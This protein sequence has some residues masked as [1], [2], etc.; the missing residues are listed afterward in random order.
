ML[1]SVPKRFEQTSEDGDGDTEDVADG[2][3][4]VTR[5]KVL[6]KRPAHQVSTMCYFCSFVTF[7]L[8][9]ACVYMSSFACH[10]V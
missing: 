2:A 7:T 9:Y 1:F 4:E 6:A 5:K 3:V 10:A 8:G